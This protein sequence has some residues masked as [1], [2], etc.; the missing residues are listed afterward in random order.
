MF[1]FVCMCACVCICDG[2]SDRC[3]SVHASATL[4]LCFGRFSHRPIYSIATPGG[5]KLLYT[6]QCVRDYITQMLS[7]NVN[8][9]L[10][11]DPVEFLVNYVFINIVDEFDELC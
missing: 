4:L 1:V 10:S 6:F 8:S 3:N 7:C 2:G 5:S 11:C 9:V